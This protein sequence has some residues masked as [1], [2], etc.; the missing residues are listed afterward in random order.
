MA[1]R[2]AHPGLGRFACATGD[3]V[4]RLDE[5]RV[6]IASL[7]RIGHQCVPEAHELVDVELIVG[8]QYE[9]LEVLGRRRRVMAQPVQRVIDA[10]RIE[11]CQRPRLAGFGLERSVGN[12][13]IHCV[14]IGEVEQIT[15]QKSPLRDHRRFNV[16]V[17][18]K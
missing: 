14:K 9:V 8:E 17:F 7:I 6:L 11:Q 15:H 10:G 3:Q 4:A 16:F 5:A 18:G 2:R 1:P 13:V 12:A